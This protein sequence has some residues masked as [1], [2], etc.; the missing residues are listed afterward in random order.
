M[1]PQRQVKIAC[2]TN[3]AAWLSIVLDA[4]LIANPNQHQPVLI[5]TKRNTACVP[6]AGALVS[7]YPKGHPALTRVCASNPREFRVDAA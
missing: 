3:L 1:P 7:L 5:E 4:D 2:L 6:A